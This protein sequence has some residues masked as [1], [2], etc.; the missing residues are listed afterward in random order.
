MEP[1][2][3][4]R[5]RTPSV[6]QP[7]HPR[8]GEAGE[9]RAPEAQPAQEGF[10]A[11]SQFVVPPDWDPRKEQL[12]RAIDAIARYSAIPAPSVPSLIQLEIRKIHAL[13]QA[14]ESAPFTAP[15]ACRT[16]HAGALRELLVRLEGYQLEL[17]G[18]E[19]PPKRDEG[20]Y[21]YEE[22]RRINENIRE[23]KAEIWAE[24]SRLGISSRP[25][26]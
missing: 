21:A 2:I 20:H 5:P 3:P 19:D 25:A 26:P 6:D 12:T 17:L 11:D 14:I 9:T 10:C 8:S 4:R 24:I 23:T 13:S 1:A 18:Y 15:P 7:P 22:L 16:T